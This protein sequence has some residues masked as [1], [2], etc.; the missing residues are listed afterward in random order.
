MAPVI[1]VGDILIGDWS[2]IRD[3]PGV[4]SEPY[5][6]DWRLVKVLGGFTLDDNVRAG[7]WNLFFMASG[8]ESMFWGI[9]GAAKLKKALMAILE[10]VKQQHFNALEVTG[11]VEKRFLGIPYTVVSAHSRHAQVS[12]YL[13][14][15][16]A[17]RISQREAEWARG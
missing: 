8:I 3:L 6:G 11:I 17:R 4:E 16:Q 9:L 15:V 13:D 5:S 14:S 2:A 12:C 7:G 1:Q 10:K